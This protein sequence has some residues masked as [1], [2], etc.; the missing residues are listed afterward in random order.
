MSIVSARLDISP[1]IIGLLPV[2]VMS[3]RLRTLTVSLTPSGRIF[4]LPSV[5]IA[6]SRSPFS[7]IPLALSILSAPGACSSSAP[8]RF[9]NSSL[10]PP[11]VA[12]TGCVSNA[13]RTKLRTIKPFP[14]PGIELRITNIGATARKGRSIAVKIAASS[15][16]RP[17]R[18]IVEI[19]LREGKQ[20]HLRC[21]SSIILRRRQ[22]NMEA[23]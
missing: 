20:Q 8:S 4:A 5:R 18:R 16:A 3:E 13:S 6:S 9:S 7:C 15:I 23:G 10:L 14:V 1:V 12:M 21:L 19:V 2:K 17:A 11:H 22:W